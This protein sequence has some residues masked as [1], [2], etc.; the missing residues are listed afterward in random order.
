MPTDFHPRCLISPDYSI[1]FNGLQSVFNHNPS[2]PLRLILVGSGHR[3]ENPPDADILLVSNNSLFNINAETTFTDAVSKTMEFVKNNIHNFNQCASLNPL[4]SQINVQLQLQMLFNQLEH[5]KQAHFWQRNYLETQMTQQPLHNLLTQINQ[6]DHSYHLYYASL[7]QQISTLQ[8]PYH[9]YCALPEN[10]AERMIADMC[11][12]GAIITEVYQK[13]KRSIIK[14]QWGKATL[15][16][17]L[18]YSATEAHAAVSDFTINTLYYDIATGQYTSAHEHACDD[19]HTKTLRASHEN[20]DLMFEK[21]ITVLFRA[22][23]IIGSEA[24]TVESQLLE[25]M[26]SLP[27]KLKTAISAMNPD[28]LILDKSILFCSGYAVNV[29]NFLEE[30]KLLDYLF[31]AEPTE[32][33][34]EK[35]QK[36]FLFR[37]VAEAC[38][39]LYHDDPENNHYPHALINDLDRN[40]KLLLDEDKN[41]KL[42]L[43]LFDYAIHHTNFPD[44]TRTPEKYTIY[45][46]N[47]FRAMHHHMSLIEQAGK[48]FIAHHLSTYEKETPE[49]ESNF[50]PSISVFPSIDSDSENNSVGGAT[51]EE[52]LSE[53]EGEK[54]TNLE[55]QT[56]APHF[57]IP[58]ETSA[59]PSKSKKKNIKRYEKNKENK[60]RES[61]AYALVSRIEINEPNLSPRI[62]LQAATL[63]DGIN[64]RN[65]A[66]KYYQ[67][68]FEAQARLKISNDEKNSDIDFDFSFIYL[69]LLIIHNELEN[70]SMANKY[71][72]EIRD[73]K[74]ISAATREKMQSYC[75]KNKPKNPITENNN[76]E[77]ELDSW[78]KENNEN[79]KCG[80]YQTV[81][82]SHQE[83]IQY[84]ETINHPDK[85]R[86]ISDL[87]RQ[88]IFC[89]IQLNK[90]IDCIPFFERINQFIKMQFSKNYP[91]LI[92]NI[93]KE[94]KKSDSSHISQENFLTK[95]LL[96]KLKTFQGKNDDALEFFQNALVI[97]QKMNATPQ[98]AV[99]MNKEKIN[100]Y[101]Y[102]EAIYEA[103]SDALDKT[104]YRARLGFDALALS[105]YEKHSKL[106]KNNAYIVE[107]IAQFGRK[108][109]ILTALI[110]KPEATIT[111]GG[112]FPA[113]TTTASSASHPSQKL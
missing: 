83:C 68:F 15:E 71:Y 35:K 33:E 80:L 84:F 43:C 60:E 44:H 81:L 62:S 47:S 56:E 98:E 66:V 90:Y 18:E 3:K 69:R 8:N 30:N 21:D 41:K 25:T 5:T 65:N 102:M 103:Q 20:I 107:K 97:A 99:L 4:I 76:S 94:I 112:F 105:C 6:L 109:G 75:Q 12:R 23:R 27:N 78:S 79:Y 39:A 38:D 64:D 67:K 17:N 82:A 10:S 26:R 28:R 74:E 1:A 49:P 110:Q 104:L 16:L 54:N 70:D 31:S 73:N 42:M 96:G 72:H 93:F 29:L 91:P 100:I 9:F 7:L 59:P 32:S 37:K 63:F 108:I 92:E 85:L 45:T 46:H 19:I 113:L 111:S 87:S 55:N 57:D 48:K 77:F 40:N 34:Q 53:S 24:Y 52:D 36:Q 51:T 22:L 2:S 58:Q 106:D 13:N 101:T 86:I 14:L 11:Y 89:C 95:S 88:A 50:T 61:R